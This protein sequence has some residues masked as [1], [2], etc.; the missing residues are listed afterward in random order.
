MER[1]KISNSSELNNYYKIIHNK[2]KK[3]AD[4]DIPVNKM[5]KYLK[6]GSKN[7]NNFISEDDELKNVDGIEV[8]LMDIINDTLSS[9]RDGLLKTSVKKFENYITENIFNKLNISDEIIIQHEKALADIYRISLSS[10]DL[11]YRDS[12]LYLVIDNGIS[13]NIMIFSEEEV[14]KIKEEII[15]V[16]IE[17]TKDKIFNFNS[18]LIDKSLNLKEI[19]DYEKIK[20]LLNNLIIED[21]I[22]R[23]IIKD[24]NLS[25]KF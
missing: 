25:N 17:N 4:I 22:I 23:S 7:F 3:F 8:V 19:F 5:V 13:R 10:I 21:D 9:F 1:K 24:N 20:N 2:L 18:Q 6:P 15:N 16:L 14:M 11:M 12:H